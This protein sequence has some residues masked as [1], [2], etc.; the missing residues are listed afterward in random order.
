MKLSKLIEAPF[1]L[2]RFMNVDEMQ[3]QRRGCRVCYNVNVRA[4][5]CQCSGYD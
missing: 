1:L 2:F 5:Q 4:K 3:C